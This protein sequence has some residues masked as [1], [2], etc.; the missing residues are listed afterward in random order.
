MKATHFIASG[1]TRKFDGQMEA[2]RPLQLVSF[3]QRGDGVFVDPEGGRITCPINPK[4]V[5][6]YPQEEQVE[7]KN[8][9]FDKP[10]KNTVFFRLLKFIDEVWNYDPDRFNMRPLP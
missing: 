2:V 9:I 8:I 1:K 7:L 4:F 10:A 5:L 6:P 3:T